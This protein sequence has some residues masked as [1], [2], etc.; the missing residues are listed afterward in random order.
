MVTRLRLRAA[1][2]L[3]TSIQKYQ[4]TQI[5]KHTQLSRNTI[6]KKNTHNYRETQTFIKKHTQLS[7]NEHNPS[8][9]LQMSEGYN[10]H[11]R[12]YFCIESK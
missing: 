9:A 2:Y 10:V 11:V 3:R 7:R 4:E 8:A 12:M 1:E 5:K 6:I